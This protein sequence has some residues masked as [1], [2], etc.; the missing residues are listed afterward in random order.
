MIDSD[1]NVFDLSTST[2]FSDTY[3]LC[4]PDISSLLNSI[5]TDGYI[6]QQNNPKRSPTYSNREE[7]EL[8]HKERLE[9]MDKLHQEDLLL[10]ENARMKWCSENKINLCKF[11][12]Y[13]NVSI[14]EAIEVLNKNICAVVDIDGVEAFIKLNKYRYP[15]RF[16]ARDTIKVNDTVS[17]TLNIV[18]Y[19]NG[20]WEVRKH[21]RQR[22]CLTSL[23][24]SEYI[25]DKF[26]VPHRIS[27]SFL[28]SR[29]MKRVVER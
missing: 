27:V 26:G 20:N 28:I 16:S 10:E 11:S 17:I 2:W 12:K 21:S 5:Q 13:L 14:E 15:E 1:G 19:P 7:N 18:Y 8:L 4:S 25:T 3:E 23:E 22:P 24:P 9:Y 6:K 29:I